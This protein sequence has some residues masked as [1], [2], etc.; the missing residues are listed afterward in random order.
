MHPCGNG[1]WRSPI[2]FSPEKI[3]VKPGIKRRVN[4]VHG[5]EI[6]QL[7]TIA[8]ALHKRLENRGTTS[9]LIHEFQ[10]MSVI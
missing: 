2:R 10:D 6:N 9:I 3:L 1:L 8:N 5:F 4:Y 7:G